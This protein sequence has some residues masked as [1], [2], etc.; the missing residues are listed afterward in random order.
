MVTW[1]GFFAPADPRPAP[2]LPEHGWMRWLIPTKVWQLTGR[3]GRARIAARCLRPSS[4]SWLMRSPFL[5]SPG[6]R[7][8]STDRSLPALHVLGHRMWI[9]CRSVS[10][11]RPSSGSA[12]RHGTPTDAGVWRSLRPRPQT[13]P[14]TPTR[15]TAT[16]SSSAT[17]V[18][19]SPAQI[20]PPRSRH[21]LPAPGPL[22][23]STATSASIFGDGAKGWRPGR[24]LRT[25]LVSRLP[26]K[27]SWPSPGWS[28]S[29]TT[30]G[31]LT[32][33]VLSGAGVNSSPASP[34]DLTGCT[35]GPRESATPHAT[36]S[37]ANSPTMESSVRS[38]SA[39]AA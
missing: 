5:A 24:W 11:A 16:G 29:T 13:S 8:M 37:S 12:S 32:A 9:C 38:S 31:R 35:P 36:K 14:A 33:H 2:R 34:R 17:T 22:A 18:S 10:R 21:F 4:P 1:I 3:S 19:T 25:G 15:H 28:A 26:V 30:P 7:C 27:R 23:V 39:S 20:Q 6:H